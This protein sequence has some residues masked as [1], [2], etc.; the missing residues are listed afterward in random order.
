[1][2]FDALAMSCSLDSLCWQTHGKRR[3]ISAESSTEELAIICKDMHLW[4]NTQ[5]LLFSTPHPTDSARGS[6]SDKDP[7]LLWVKHFS[8]WPSDRRGG[9]RQPS[10]NDPD[11]AK[12]TGS[13]SGHSSKLSE[14][15]LLTSVCKNR[16]CSANIKLS[17][18]VP[19]LTD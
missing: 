10:A 17:N 6:G 3:L 16:R 13:G 8:H 19:L 11:S 2:F 18:T 12:C 5:G 9:P 1:M 4:H 15:L 7:L 14:N